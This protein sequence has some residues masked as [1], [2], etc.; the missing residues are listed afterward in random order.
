MT[1]IAELI[2]RDSLV[3][4]P[5]GT[6][7]PLALTRALVDARH[8]IGGC[9]VLLGAVFSDTFTPVTADAL[10]FIS[11][12]GVGGVGALVQ[13]GAC[14]VIPAHVSELPR[15]LRDMDGLRPDVVLVQL[16][17]E[18]VDGRH[19]V[20]VV[21]DYVRTAIDLASVVIGQVNRHMPYVNGA[22]T[23]ALGELDYVVYEDIPLLE[24]PV[25]AYGPVEDAIAGHIAGLVRDGDCLQIGIGAIP[26][27]MLRGLRDKKHLGVHS[28][29]ISDPVADLIRDGV[30]DNS[31]KEIDAGV[32]V[33]GVLFGTAALYEFANH[34]PSISLRE[35]EY[36]HDPRTLSQL[37]NLVSVNSAI[38]IDATGQVNAEV[39]GDRYIGAIGGQVDFVRAG[40]LSPGGRS[41]IALPATAS[42]GRKSRIVPR[43]G[44]GIVT[45]PRSEVDIVVTEYGVAYLRGRSFDERRRNLAAIAAPEFRESLLATS[46]GI[47]ASVEANA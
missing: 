12:G 30:I 8:Q 13:A 11:L 22:A 41:I 36:T 28:G 7:E 40:R 45:T 23:V 33:A 44:E 47:Q 10:S 9:R 37:S 38:E 25:A 18:S 35:L 29:L 24:V 3:V 19:S 46:P 43:L 2:R 16:S 31:R 1:G 6:A 5:Q 14:S 20:G 15:L 21:S 4:V 32:S 34:N 17:G 39:L 26:T 42:H 27:A